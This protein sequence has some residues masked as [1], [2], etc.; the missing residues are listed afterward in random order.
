MS[1]NPIS[2]IEAEAR[3][4]YRLHLTFDDGKEQSVDFKPFLTR[5]QHPD[6]RSYLDPAKFAMSRIEYGELVWGD[7]DLCFPVIDLYLNQ[8]GHD[9]R[10]ETAA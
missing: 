4:D 6:I 1:Q 5:V 3:G 10:Q 2:I 8:L 7:Y 9:S